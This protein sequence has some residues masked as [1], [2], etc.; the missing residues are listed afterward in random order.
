MSDSQ[1]DP[2]SVIDQLVS[3][4]RNDWRAGNRPRI[5]AYLEGNP[6]LERRDLFRAFLAAEM[7]ERRMRGES[8]AAEEYG[9]RFREFNDLVAEEFGDTGTSLAD[10]SKA[11]LCEPTGNWLWQLP[12]I[13]VAESGT[14]ENR[15][16]ILG[17][18]GA[19]AF[20]TVHK[21]WDTQVGRLVALKTPRPGVLRSEA[22]VQRFLREA[23]AAGQ[24]RHRNIVTVH[25]AGKIGET[26]YIVSDFIEGQTL[27][28]R[29]EK[30]GTF[31]GRDSALLIQKVAMAL[32]EAHTRGII[33]RDVKPANVMIDSV[34]EPLVMDFG[35][36]RRDE[37]EEL[38]T[39]SGMLIGTPA[40]MSPEQHAGESHLA[41]AR[42]DQWALGVMLYELLSGKR[43]FHGSSAQ[44]GSIVREVEPERLSELDSRI[45]RDL[46][47]ICLKCLEK[48]PRKRYA[49]CQHLAED[50]SR[51][52]R[53]EPISA[54]RVGQAERA[55]RWCRRNP[56]IATLSLTAVVL[57]FIVALVGSIGYVQT[58]SALQRVGEARDDAE[59]ARDQEARQRKAA[60]RER[61]RSERLRYVSDMKLAHRLWEARDYRTSVA[62][63]DDYEGK[64]RDTDLC[65]WEW[66][67]LRHLV[68][69]C[70]VLRSIPKG[71]EPSRIYCERAMAWSGD[72]SRI[73]AT[74]GGHVVIWAAK[75]W[76]NV[77][78][79]ASGRDTS[80]DFE[81]LYCVAWNPRDLRLA[82]G[83]DWGEVLVWDT[84]G[85]GKPMILRGHDG[86]V[87]S[88]AWSPDGE[89]L[90]SGSDDETV[91]VWDGTNGKEILV[92]QHPRAENPGRSVSASD[93]G[94]WRKSFGSSAR[95]PRNVYYVMEEAPAARRLDQLRKQTSALLKQH[96]DANQV[97]AVGWTS[98]GTRLACGCRDGSVRMWDAGNGRP[99]KTL[100]GHLHAARSV[101]WHPNGK[102]LA[103]ASFDTNEGRT[104]V[105]DVDEGRELAVYSGQSPVWS[106]GGSRLAISDYYEHRPC[107][108]RVVDVTTGIIDL[109]TKTPEDGIGDPVSARAIHV[110]CLLAW[111][112]DGGLLS[113]RSHKNVG[114]LRV[115]DVRLRGHTRA[116]EGVA[117]RPDGKQW[118]TAGGDGIVRI[119]DVASRSEVAALKDH[120]KPVLTVAWSPDGRYISTGGADATVRI[121]QGATGEPVATLPCPGTEIHTLAWS[122][123]GKRLISAGPSNPPTIWSIA[124]CRKIVELPGWNEVVYATAWSRGGRYLVTAGGD[125]VGPGHH[126]PVRVWDSETFT[127]IHE[128]TGHTKS[129]LVAA[130]SPDGEYLATSG[131]DKTLRIWETATGRDLH[132]IRLDSPIHSLAWS[133]DGGRLASGDRAG[134][135]IIWE[136]TV[137]G[138]ILSVCGHAG[139]VTSIAWS[140]DQHTLLTGSTDTTARIWETDVLPQEHE[141]S[142]ATY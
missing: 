69:D 54:R 117:W 37:G 100:W 67:Y 113:V 44:I 38:R 89:R 81:E 95:K 140:P 75:T 51:W 127:L 92:L 1:S 99:C 39:Q 56:L 59:Y 47:T 94:S 109:I 122:P 76:E 43:P 118:A 19:G 55:W 123:D 8:P 16:R 64:A 48:E 53:G 25:D 30:E 130:F 141:N 9:V 23:R 32:H 108:T 49:S 115:P 7:H 84:S 138:A 111:S 6:R 28:A 114:L 4:F 34:G 128:L 14:P 125:R 74:A 90:A 126:S 35:M 50:L 26:Y 116:I 73:A 142:T 45:S 42:S 134:S 83:N 68:K 137:G 70:L 129:V 135:L 22:D 36:A 33:H 20:G 72:G 3:R 133:P 2:L 102:W 27:A 80:K 62:L 131:E 91:R 97:L 87:R 104:V 77:K 120:A 46:E 29:L 136:P 88:L 101:S 66:Y 86:V 82:A 103:S 63:L 78:S 71:G 15:Y 106:P 17:Q 105:W 18:L 107:A 124:D 10:S 5:E 13:H 52:L 96:R 24:F 121:W 93:T 98:D 112:P 12:E 61:D 85:N 132:A 11:E 41:D 57:L 58:S 21:A 79:F 119:W 110:G 65:H 60:E 40:Y 139:T 31:S